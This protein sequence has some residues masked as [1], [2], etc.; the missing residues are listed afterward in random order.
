VNTTFSRIVNLEFHTLG[1][2]PK[3]LELEADASELQELSETGAIA[4][5]HARIEVTP[6]AGEAYLGQGEARGILKLDCGRCLEALDQPFFIKFNLLMEKS[7]EKGL[8]WSDDGDQG[9]EDY[10]VKI[11]S[12]I[13]EIPLDSI[14]AEQV[15]LNYNLHPLPALDAQNKCVQCGRLAFTAEETK[16]ADKVDPRWAGLQGLKDSG[17]KDP[18]GPD[19]GEKRGKA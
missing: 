5:V 7:T 13:R 17:K 3:T 1:K 8:S 11:G 14:I 15:L 6:L 19:S 18:K 10:Q 4:K 9:V 16:R 12:D 2:D